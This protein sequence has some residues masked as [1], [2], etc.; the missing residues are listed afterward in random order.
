MVFDV[1]ANEGNTSTEFRR[2]LPD[3][4]IHAFEP[5]PVVYEKL[6]VRTSRY[7]RVELN[8]VAVGSACGSQTFKLYTHPHRNSFLE[9]GSRWLALMSFRYG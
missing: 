5:D 1:G 7:P 8:N 4:E 6:V 3:C 9:P 2:L